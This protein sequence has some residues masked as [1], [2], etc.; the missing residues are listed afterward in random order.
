MA[1]ESTLTDGPTTDTNRHRVFNFSPGPAT[2]PLE[3]LEIAKNEFLDYRGSGMSIIESSHRS[4]EYD[5]INEEAIALTR[6]LL[7]LDDRFHVIFVGGGASTQFAHVPM[8][9]LPEGKI[10]A[11][12]DT[13][14]WSAK[15]IKEA[16]HFGSVE[17]VASSKESDYTFI[18]QPGDFTVPSDAAYLHLTTNN[19]IFGTQWQSLPKPTVPL[20][21]DM[22]SDFMSRRHPFSDF[23]LIYAGAQKNIGPAGATMVIIRDDFLATAKEGLPTMFDYRTHTNKKSLYNT[24]PVFAVYIIKLVM[25]W[26]KEHGGLSWIEAINQRKQQLVYDL[27]D[28]DSDFFRGT[29]RP[30][31]R[32][33]MNITLRLPSEELESRLIT[34]AKAAGFA[35]LKGHRSVGG[36][37]ISAYNAMPTAGIEQLVRFMAD[38]R[39]SA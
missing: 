23:S 22:S 39:K 37:R 19:T 10:A 7:G 34:E 18:P 4:K 35:G 14:S 26:L 32:S 3:V 13:G 2:L 30:D 31:S 8:S 15:A 24:P 20:V 28:S 11:Y 12:V 33:W 16:K 6:E 27:I 36:I 38:F 21:A 1:S 17:V 5:A 9:F 29:V 25:E